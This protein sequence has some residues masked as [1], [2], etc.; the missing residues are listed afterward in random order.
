MPVR[1]V[2]D[3]SCDLPEDL[4][5]QLGIEI[6][7]L[8]IRFGD[9][10]Y[11]DRVDLSADEFWS[12]MA[13]SPVLPETAAPSAGAFEETF[14]RLGTEGADAVVCVSL[15]SKL[16]ATIQSAQVAANAVGDDLRIEVVDSLTVALA[17][18]NL[19]R[20]AAE[21]ANDGADADTIVKLVETLRDRSRLFGAL[22]T[23][24]N[25][26][27]GGRVGGAQA[28]LGSM[29]SIK[30]VLAIEDGQVE[31]WARVRT[32]SKA[33]R[34]LVDKVK[35]EGT[36]EDLAILHGNAPDVNILVEMF[37]PLYPPDEILVATMGPVVGAHGGARI[38]GV[39]YHTPG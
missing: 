18:G 16:S 35:E 14:R 33:L 9:D 6:V 2:T 26:K 36:V 8:T 7:P 17:L 29:L 32:R 3:S 15:S 20:R 31:P 10:E 22:D 19:A 27:K 21:A 37:E 4:A 12:K 5:K 28:L 34:W 23:L 1:I 11:V 13:S 38:I 30:P 39:T 25:L 24:E